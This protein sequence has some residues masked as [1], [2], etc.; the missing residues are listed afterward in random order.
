MLRLF[1]FNIRLNHLSSFLRFSIFRILFAV[2]FRAI[3]CVTAFSKNAVAL[4]SSDSPYFLKW[5]FLFS[6]RFSI[7]FICSQPSR[8]R[9]YV[10]KQFPSIFHHINMFHMVAPLFLLDCLY[11]S[12]IAWSVSKN[13]NL[14]VFSLT[15]WVISIIISS[16]VMIVSFCMCTKYLL[17]KL[18]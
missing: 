15:I 1:K 2:L 8:H 10:K 16:V 18:W 9:L 6:H 13:T 3:C 5:L 12:S 7:N 14:S 4:F 17:C 11:F